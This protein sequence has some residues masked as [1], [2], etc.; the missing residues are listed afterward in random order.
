M[1]GAT[2]YSLDREGYPDVGL[3]PIVVPEASYAVVFTEHGLW[4]LPDLCKTPRTRFAQVLGRRWRTRRP[5]AP[6]A[7]IVNA[8]REQNKPE[9]GRSD[10][11]ELAPHQAKTSGSLRAIFDIGT[12]A[13]PAR[14]A[15]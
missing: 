11:P 10:V 15:A 9:N 7:L 5:Q 8:D 6:Q 13:E 1:N 12:A 4:I 14:P 2:V 3:P